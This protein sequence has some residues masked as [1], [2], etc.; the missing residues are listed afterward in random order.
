VIDMMR[1][2]TATGLVAL[3]VAGLAGT[4]AAFASSTHST[5]APTAAVSHER[6]PS[7]NSTRDG[8]R[9]THSGD[10]ARDRNGLH[11]SG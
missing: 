7:D 3:A 9:D 8:T 6:S 10:S 1:K 2:L 5:K 11:E 4:G